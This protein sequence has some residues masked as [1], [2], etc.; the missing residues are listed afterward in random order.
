MVRTFSLFTGR[1][2]RKPSGVFGIFMLFIKTIKLE[3]HCLP[4]LIICLLSTQV[5]NSILAGRIT[6]NSC[7]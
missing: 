1:D 4:N 3:K 2:S 6:G 7:G 5:E